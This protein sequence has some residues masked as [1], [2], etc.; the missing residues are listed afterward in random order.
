MTNLIFTKFPKRCP[1]S[2]IILLT[3][4]LKMK[5]SGLVN[6]FYPYYYLGNRAGDVTSWGLVIF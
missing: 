4:G 5:A 6:K 3:Q 2:N 1:K